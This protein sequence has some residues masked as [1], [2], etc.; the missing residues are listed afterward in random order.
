MVEPCWRKSTRSSNVANCVEVAR[1][2]R[3]VAF[4]DSKNPT[5]PVLSIPLDTARTFLTTLKT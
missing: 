3:A 4:R 2:D 5:G 1:V